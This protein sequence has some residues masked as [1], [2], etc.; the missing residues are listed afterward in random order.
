MTSRVRLMSQ[1]PEP[2]TSRFRRE[3]CALIQPANLAIRRSIAAGGWS[4]VAHSQT[5][6]TRQLRS[7][8]S[9]ATRLSRLML[10]RIFADQKAF[11][12]L[13]HLK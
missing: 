3:S 6:T 1:L 9:R 10:P 2:D 8:S 7:R 12:V 11:R 13:G 4:R 5:V